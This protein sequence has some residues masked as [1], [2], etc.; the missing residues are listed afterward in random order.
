MAKRRATYRRRKRVKNPSSTEE[1]IKWGLIAAAGYYVYTQWSTWFP[2][3]STTT[4]LPASTPTV[5]SGGGVSTSTPSSAPTVAT[6]VVP[7]SPGGVTLPAPFQTSAGAVVADA[8]YAKGYA[9]T[10][11]QMLQA[12]A[13]SG[14]FDAD[15]WLF[16][17]NQ[18]SGDSVTYEQLS[19]PTGQDRSTVLSVQGFAAVLPTANSLS[20]LHGLASFGFPSQYTAMANQWRARWD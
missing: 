12:A 18:M 19:V 17:Y 9:P 5:V 1:I 3:T 8:N 2:S 16:Y 15:Q 14:S 6:L 4:A 11:T 20:G 13:G 7:T 10:A